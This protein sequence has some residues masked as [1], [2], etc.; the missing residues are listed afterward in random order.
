MWELCGFKFHL[1]PHCA[2]GWK[3]SAVKRITIYDDNKGWWYGVVA[4]GRAKSI[5]SARLCCMHVCVC[6]GGGLGVEEAKVLFKTC[7]T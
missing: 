7:K 3:A 5:S 4:N 1:Y 2:L 6:S